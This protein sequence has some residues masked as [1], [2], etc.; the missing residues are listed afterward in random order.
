MFTTTVDCIHGEI[1]VVS[2]EIDQDS[3]Y[4]IESACETDASACNCSDR[5]I[6]DLGIAQQEAEWLEGL[7][8]R[9]SSAN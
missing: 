7:K 4:W 2:G 9:G 8:A 3:V 6:Q 5:T 1:H